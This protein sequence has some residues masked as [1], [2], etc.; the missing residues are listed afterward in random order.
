VTPKQ[1]STQAARERTGSPTSIILI[2]SRPDLDCRTGNAVD[3][4]AWLRELGLERYADAFEANAIDH[5]V[6]PDVTEADLEKLG[7]LL[8][9]RKKLLRAIAD[10]AERV[11]DAAAP[12]CEAGAAEQT[13]RATGA[14]RRQLTV[15]FC[16]LV[17]STALSAQLDPEDMREVIRA[18]QNTVAGEIGRLEGHVAKYMGDGVLA[19]FGWPQ[20]HEDD[21]ERAVRAGLA[22]AQAIGQLETPTGEM[23][24]ARVGIATGLVVVGDL[25]GEGAAQEEAVV[26]DTPN[27][28][29]RLQGIAEPNQVIVG[30]ATRRLIG[31]AFQL[32]DLGDQALKGFPQS[33]SAW[34]VVGE[35]ALE[36]RF[37][38]AHSGRLTN[39]VGR[40]H[41]IGLL[42][43]RWE[44][45][46]QGEGQV[47]LLSGEAGIGKSRVVERVCERAADKPHTRLR[48]QCSPHFTST[49]LYPFISQ[50]ERAAEFTPDDTPD[51]KLGKLE[52]YLSQA[53]EKMTEA[54]PLIASLLSVATANRYPPQELTP[55]QQKR[56]TLEALT[57]QLLWQSTRQPVLMIFEDAHWMDPSSLEALEQM[58][59]QVQGA[60]VL[61][62]IT[63][64]PEFTP[65]WHGHTHITSLALNRLG[66]QQCAAIVGYVTGGKRLPNEVLDLILAKAD[67]V[68]LFAE[69]L[70]KTVLES[71]Q[72]Q[73][74]GDG[75]EMAGPL[76][77]VA[78]PSTLQDSLTA[79][80]DR[81][82]PIK[83]VAQIG[84]VIGREFS[85]ELLKAAAGKSEAALQSALEKL[86]SSGLVFMRGVPPN[87]T[88]LF[89]HALIR[90]AAYESLLR[91][92]RRL[93][94]AK[95]AKLLEE[96]LPA[97]AAN[98]PEL[99]A[100][101]LSESG[102]SAKSID[103]W[104]MAAKHALSRAS[105]REALSF[106]DQSQA[107]VQVQA[108]TAETMALAVDVRL[109]KY[110]AQYTLGKPQS[111]L[112]LLAEAESIAIRMKDPV[113]LSKVLSVQT[114]ILSA[115]GQVDV[116][117]AVGERNVDRIT[118][119]DGVNVFC[120][121]K[122]MLG[123]AL[124]AAGRYADAI[125]H[126]QDVR[127]IV[128]DDRRGERGTAWR[129]SHTINA[130]AMLVVAHAERGEFER[131]LRLGGHGLRLLKGGQGSKHERL[132]ME[133]AIGRL[134]V[135]K[136][137]F[138]MAVAGLEPVLSFCES[139]YPVY[140]TRLAASLGMAHAA[141]GDID[142]GLK[143]LRQADDQ[144]NSIGFQFGQALVLSQLAEVL[145]RAG[146]R[147]EAREKA[148]RA[149]ELAQDTGERG[150]EGWAECVLGDV[151][152]E[153]FE[154]ADAKA[155]YSR[156]LE[157]AD[158]LSMAPLR[159]RCLEGLRRCT[160]RI[161]D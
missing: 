23:L 91:Q 160:S 28:A 10:L 27:L 17:G 19:Y 14:E 119:S 22:L 9:H 42:L 157:I 139:D 73:I 44:Q 135:V 4:S 89:K 96:R 99:I 70:T 121:A 58:I 67:G 155:H 134:N 137:N 63:H 47:V 153:S 3:I 55:Q 49:A 71:G 69:E 145:L 156:A 120:N 147:A 110:A 48:F 33:V 18:Y 11:G 31:D 39:F 60:R 111:V 64:R 158:A 108:K 74:A 142:K 103:Y 59:D 123:R 81:L 45:A 40:E 92:Q 13:N 20:A 46:E 26:G 107:A 52:A 24:V 34:R 21:A 50:L 56:L 29:A 90:D 65:P 136:G 41:E 15:L 36:S 95:I 140:F 130:L 78:V 32:E 159:G 102:Q 93:L 1:S 97:V 16:D 127:E 61:M 144:A 131:G 54:L 83:E 115:A 51:A 132:W 87:S 124:Y 101:H 109:L 84:A 141:S 72:L 143:L 12:A 138:A 129:P 57:N 80:L 66:R 79:R 149:V 104:M 86:V 94:H 82:A 88:Y 148:A 113:R 117:V 77:S 125:H 146:K 5:E 150:N 2:V 161:C 114:Y 68:P 151:S 76:S 154:P 100:Y 85:H 62:V 37:E 122:L 25:V 30:E 128:G 98:Q 106:A 112:A 8:G 35:R 118:E 133:I 126:V 43:G 7:V 152:A 53:T 6:L 116:A 75:Y 105:F 38:A